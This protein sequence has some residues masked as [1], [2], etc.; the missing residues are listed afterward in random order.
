MK[1][2]NLV[3]SLKIENFNLNFNN[4]YYFK[5][6]N[7]YES[8]LTF[9][10]NFRVYSFFKLNKFLDKNNLK[11][12]NFLNI[13]YIYF[14]F[15]WIYFLNT[16]NLLYYY[17]LIKI[18]LDKYNQLFL[19]NNN[20][21]INFK[22]FNILPTNYLNFFNIKKFKFFEYKIEYLKK[23]NSEILKLPEISVWNCPTIFL[24]N[25]LQNS[26]FNINFLRT[27]RRYNKRRYSKVRVVSRTSFFSGIALSSIFLGILWGGSIKNVDWL[28]S[29]IIVIDINFLI[30]T[31]IL[32]FLFRIWRL[33]YINTFIRK[34]NK[35]RIVTS[36]HKMFIFNFWIKKFKN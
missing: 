16:K 13:I 11:K 2:P 3:L 29:W 27:Q 14:N 23:L 1:K 7:T 12:K 34:K 36:L 26:K 30:F 8:T 15:M 21:I 9:D 18:S 5:K 17:Y 32:Y 6:K 19:N 33:K 10:Y 20:N 31:L 28:T 4:L 24:K 25:N 35:I 22:N